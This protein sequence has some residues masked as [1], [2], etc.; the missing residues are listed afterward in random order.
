MRIAPI[1]IALC[2][3]L[4][5]GAAA[6]TGQERAAMRAA[7]IVLI[8][9]TH[10]NPHHHARQA[11][12]VAELAPRALVFEMLTP[13][14]AARVTPDLIADPAAMLDALDWTLSGWPD[15]AMYHPIFAA[16]PRARVLGAAV[17]RDAA[18][19]AIATGAAQAFGAGAEAYG[20]AGALPQD[21]QERREDLQRR[22]H[23][24]ALPVEMLAGMVEVQRLRDAS[25]ARAAIE[26]LDAP[27][28]GPVVVITGNGH[29]RRDWGVPAY[30]QRVAP[31]AAVF[32]LGQSEDGQP[33]EG[34]FDAVADS[35]AA[36]REDPCG[37]FRRDG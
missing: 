25:L 15:F 13:E 9:E 20:L 3:L 30:L 16:A 14:Q 32:S 35:P 29:A 8:G 37:A 7:D 12:L 34:G 21:M 28:A 1:L 10:D 6:L 33:P 27:G 36:D 17:P 24:D 22:A 4:A 18:R 31:D 2:L 19:E 26:G 5:G 11:R 23:C